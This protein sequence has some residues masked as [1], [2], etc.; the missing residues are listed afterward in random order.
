MFFDYS[1][2]IRKTIYIDRAIESLT[3]SLRKI[4]KTCRSFPYVV[5]VMKALYLALHQASKKRTRP[6]RNWK[7]AMA[8]FDIMYQDW[9]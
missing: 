3:A 1:A 7:P 4:A 6:I 2:E 5:A 8:Q 9:F